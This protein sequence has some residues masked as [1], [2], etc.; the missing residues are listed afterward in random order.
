MLK[1]K[2]TKGVIKL[3]GGPTVVVKELEVMQTKLMHGATV[4]SSFNKICSDLEKQ[5]ILHH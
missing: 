4:K 5:K 2:K 1:T 3:G